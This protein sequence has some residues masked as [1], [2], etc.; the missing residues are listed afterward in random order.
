[1]ARGVEAA[2][3]VCG[4]AL[5]FTRE[6]LSIQGF[7]APMTAAP[8]RLRL[9]LLVDRTS[10]EAFGNDGEASVSACFLPS[11]DSLALKCTRG[12]LKVVS[13]DCCEL[14]SIWKGTPKAH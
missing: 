1:M 2:F 11:D 3:R 7:T 5:A 14:E 4:E 9:E 12:G 13:M 6:T 10:I 8:E